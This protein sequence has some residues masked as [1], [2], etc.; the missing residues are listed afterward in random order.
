M[1]LWR[2]LFN[3]MKNNMQK[4]A[5][6]INK[7]NKI[8][9]FSMDSKTLC[10]GLTSSFSAFCA[11]CFYAFLSLSWRLEKIIY[12][13]HKVT[14]L[15]ILSHSWIGIQLH[16]SVTIDCNNSK[17]SSYFTLFS[18]ELHNTVGQSDSEQGSL[19]SV[20]YSVSWSRYMQLLKNVVECQSS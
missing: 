15:S 7:D 6:T 13:R 11:W 17:M 4:T 1:C 10:L 12:Q 3:C 16:R 19:F 14:E 5:S 9:Q 8:Y 2:M 20:R 18:P